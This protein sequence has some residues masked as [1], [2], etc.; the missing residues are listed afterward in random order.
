MED[1]IFYA[2]DFDQVKVEGC[3]L[4]GQTNSTLVF[5]DGAVLFHHTSSSLSI[6]GNELDGV[7]VVSVDSTTGSLNYITVDTQVAFEANS[8][9]ISV[10]AHVV[11]MPGLGLSGDAILSVDEKTFDCTFENITIDPACGIPNGGTMTINSISLDFS[12]TTCADPSVVVFAGNLSTTMPI[13]DIMELLLLEDPMN[14]LLAAVGGDNSTQEAI[15]NLLDEAGLWQAEDRLRA[16]KIEGSVSDLFGFYNGF[17]FACGTLDAAPLQKKITITFDGSEPCNAAGEVIVEVDKPDDTF[18]YT[19]TFNNVTTQACTINGQTTGSFVFGDS[20]VT[21]THTSSNLQ[22][23]SNTFDGTSAV[24]INTSDGSLESITIDTDLSLEMDGEAVVVQAK[25]IYDSNGINGTADIKKG[26]K[27]Y[28][29]VFENVT[30]DTA[31]G[32]PNG[33]IITINGIE[34]DFEGTT[35]ASPNVTVTVRG[36]SVEMSLEDAVA[37]LS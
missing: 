2:M 11:Y 17:E 15:G 10:D 27:T 7:F 21:F 31:C 35:C 26:R 14:A 9:Q 23:C 29:C 24:V 4:D 22:F 32:I 6:C 16:R 33:G 36:R 12:N 20:T 28:E 30:I 25:L 37:M 1:G 13:E 5:G 19:L 18:L 34:M 3:V 8:R